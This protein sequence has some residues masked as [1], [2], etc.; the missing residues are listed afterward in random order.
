MITREPIDYPVDASSW[1]RAQLALR[2]GLSELGRA[3]VMGARAVSGLPS[4]R[5]PRHWTAFLRQMYVVGIGSLPVVTVVAVFIGMILALQIGLELQR[6]NQE[7][8]I[9]SAV[10]ISMLRE[11]APFVTGL[12]LAACVGS[13][14]AAQIGTMTVNDEIAALEIMSI[15]PVIFLMTPRLAALA[16]LAPLLSFYTCMMGTLGGAVVGTT[17]LNVPWTQYV[18]AALDI[19]RVKDLYVGLF[20]AMAYGLLIAVV[21]CYEGFTAT[22]GAMGVGAATRRSVVTSFLLILIVGYF[23]SRLFYF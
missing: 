23:I 13:A 22:Q 15:D 5:Q 21:S 8:R 9:G 10:M 14:M 6:Y 2:Q 7:V 19:A 16:I 20:K 12:I 3:T 18:S 1:Q 17:Q 4:L 11:M